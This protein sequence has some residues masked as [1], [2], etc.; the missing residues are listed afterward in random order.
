LA[1]GLF[2][3][4]VFYLQKLQPLGETPRPVW[5][6]RFL[7]NKPLLVALAVVMALVTALATAYVVGFLDSVANINRNLLDEP[8]VTIYLLLPPASYFGLA[9]VYILVLSAPTGE[10][11]DPAGNGYPLVSFLGLLGVNMMA[12][13]LAIIT[14]VLVDRFLPAGNALWPGIVLYFLLLFLFLPPR[15]IYLAKVNHP[16]TLL[17]FLVFLAFLSAT[18]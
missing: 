15:F 10:T 9:L 18:V 12:A 3:V 4:A 8:A 13:V 7:A 6:T 16:I 11:I 1:F 14:S 5:L 17:T 2:C